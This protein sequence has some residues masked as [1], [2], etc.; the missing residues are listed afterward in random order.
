MV[1]LLAIGNERYGQWAYNLAL[2]IKS[3]GP[4][5]IQLVYDPKTMNKIKD[6]TVF[7]VRTPIKKEHCYSGHLFDPA[8]AKL[9]LNEYLEF[10]EAFYFDVDAIC[11][12]DIREMQI[13]QFYA[14]EVIGSGTFD[15]KSFGKNMYWASPDV[16]VKYYPEIKDKRLDFINSSFQFLR[17]CPELDA[18]YSQAYENLTE[19]TIP[20]HE[21]KEKW[22]KKGTG[23][24]D[25]LYMNIALC[26]LD[27]NARCHEKPVYFNPANIPPIS[28]SEIRKKHYLLGYFGDKN[29][30][31]RSIKGM[32]DKMMKNY[33]KQRGTNHLFHLDQLLDRKYTSL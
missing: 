12:Q 29:T 7:D 26:Q 28:L 25:E 1:I 15:Q 8:R 9:K 31:H 13:N 17:K 6:L 4:I 10:D 33:T 20:K 24:P 23:Q 21:L 2:S 3:F 16:I 19:R 32:Y 14:S 18:L 5:P 22:G 30:S 27:I 11:V